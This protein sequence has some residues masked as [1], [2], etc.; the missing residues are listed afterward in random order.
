MI[1]RSGNRRLFRQQGRTTSRFFLAAPIL[2][3]PGRPNT[4]KVSLCFGRWLWLRAGGGAVWLG[5]VRGSGTCCWGRSV[6]GRFG[7]WVALSSIGGFGVGRG[8]GGGTRGPDV[9]RGSHGVGGSGGII[10]AMSP[11]RK[12]EGPGWTPERQ[13]LHA[14]IAHH[15]DLLAEY[16][17]SAIYF[18]HTPTAPARLSTGQQPQTCNSQTSSTR[19]G[20]GGRPSRASGATPSTSLR[21]T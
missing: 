20:T 15:N 21:T 9:G 11:T 10:C 2:N 7:G 8:P 5:S 4:S 16:Y 18:L 17:A 14:L 13:E 1:Q 3:T 19:Q 12:P 6:T